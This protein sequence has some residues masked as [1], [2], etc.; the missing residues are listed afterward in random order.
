M[1]PTA[2]LRP[3]SE[4]TL[5]SV[6]TIREYRSWIQEM[7]DRGAL[8]VVSHSG[9]KDSQA[10][11]AVLRT[12]VPHDQIAVVHANLGD[13]AEWSGTMEHAAA[14][15]DHPLEIAQAIWSDRPD[16]VTGANN[17]A[18]FGRDK[19]LPDLIRQRQQFPLPTTR[20]CTSDLKRGPIQKVIKRLSKETGRKLI[21]DCWGL[22]AEESS[23]RAAKVPVERSKSKG[24]N[25]A[26]REVWTFLPVHSATLDQV[27]TMIEESGQTR[28]QA[29]DLGMSRL[30]CVFCIMASNKDLKIAAKANPVLLQ[31]YAGLEDETGHTFRKGQRL[32]DIVGSPD[33]LE[34]EVP[35]GDELC[36]TVV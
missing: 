35:F 18:K 20:Q 15:I 17:L 34:D 36:D 14:N 23:D 11:Y 28:H 4:D 13:Q 30:S 6:D 31:L 16:T 33:S 8:F 3:L 26:G 27:W 7:V 9:G 19:W 10:M 21:I 1:Q 24:L 2:T 12:L 25:A 22:R 5:N 29:Y 32:M